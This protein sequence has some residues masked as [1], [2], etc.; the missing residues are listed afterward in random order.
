MGSV[1]YLFAAYAVIWVL[2]G[3]YLIKLGMKTGEL[4][5]RLETIEDEK[6]GD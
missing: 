4:S 1:E 6:G 3:G 2:L 5:R